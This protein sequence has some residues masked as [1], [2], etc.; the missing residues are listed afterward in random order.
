MPLA[1]LGLLA[2]AGFQEAF[3][4]DDPLDA[5]FRTGI[6][7][8]HKIPAVRGADFDGKIWDFES[9]RGPKGAVLHFYRSADW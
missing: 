1:L 6:E 9:I 8:G 7:V 2:L 5:D 3:D 4:T